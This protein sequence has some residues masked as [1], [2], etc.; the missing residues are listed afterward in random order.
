MFLNPPELPSGPGILHCNV[1]WCRLLGFHLINIIFVF[2]ETK[3]PFP[4]P[5]W[6]RFQLTSS[7][8]FSALS[9]SLLLL[10][11]LIPDW[12]PLGVSTVPPI[13]YPSSKPAPW[14]GWM[15]T[16]QCCPQQ[17]KPGFASWLHHELAVSLSINVTSLGLT[18]LIC[19]MRDHDST[20]L[21]R[22]F[23]G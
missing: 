14:W 8:K 2:P 18:S 19:K 9:L 5:N 4:S 20:H 12:E 11:S 23:W 17:Q 3:C 21:T 13:P 15:S 6:G 10:E 7:N 22:L 1:S 16:W